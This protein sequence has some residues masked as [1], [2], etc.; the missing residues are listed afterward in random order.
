M[1]FIELNRA[2]ALPNLQAVNQARTRWDDIAKPVGSLGE[3]EKLL[4]SIAGITGDAEIPLNKRA[5]LVFCA[6]NGVLKQGVAQTPPEIT[7]VMAGF[8]AQKRSSVCIMADYARA[9]VIPVDMGMFSQVD[10]PDLLNR[11]IGDGT[12]DMTAGPAMTRAQGERAIQTGMDLVRDCAEK[13]YHILA[14]GEMGIGNTTTSSAMAAVLL[15]QP[16]EAVTGRGAGLSD[17]GLIRKQAAIHKA[18]ERNRPDQADPLDVLCKVG[19]FDIAAMCG[20]FLG[21]A[22]YRV[23][24]IVDGFISMVAALCAGRLCP[25]SRMCMLPS[26]LSAEPA[27]KLIAGELAFSPVLHAG[28]RLGE[29]TGAVALL[30]LLDMAAAV[31]HRLM[32]YEEIGM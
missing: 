20:V 7:G 22:L 25:K 19:G 2:M 18:I 32:T 12:A 31:Y 15:N 8:I 9:D 3:L 16:V 26:H 29:G 23:P 17:E 5:V 11:R 1:D 30:P 10:V 14:T 24:V 21:G 4:T 27:A 13:G 28:M 6:D